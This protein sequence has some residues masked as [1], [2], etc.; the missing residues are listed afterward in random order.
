ML[1]QAAFR[2]LYSASLY[3][4]PCTLR[5]EAPSH[6]SSCLCQHMLIPRDLPAG[7]AQGRAHDSACAPAEAAKPGAA[8][9]RMHHRH[10]SAQAATSVQASHHNSCH[11]ASCQACTPGCRSACCKA[12]AAGDHPEKCAHLS[13][14]ETKQHAAGGWRTARQSECSKTGPSAALG[15]SPHPAGVFCKPCSIK[16]FHGR[17]AGCTRA[18]SREGLKQWPC[19]ERALGGRRAAKQGACCLSSSS[20]V[21]CL[22][23]K[24]F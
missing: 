9:H 11:A 15:H 22:P 24:E 21:C 4:L 5:C 14:L 8:Q 20:S 23:I 3:A 2:I 13:G 10:A 16:D 1:T 17:Q 12:A 6:T 7:A 18:F 19:P